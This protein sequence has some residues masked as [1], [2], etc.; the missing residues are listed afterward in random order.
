MNHRS[1]SIGVQS[2]YIPSKNF[3]IHLKQTLPL[4]F[5]DLFVLDV[6]E[7]ITSMDIPSLLSSFLNFLGREV[8]HHTGIDGVVQRLRQMCNEAASC[9]SE[10]HRSY[11]IE[12]VSKNPELLRKMASVLQNGDSF[13]C[14]ICI[15]PLVEP[16]ITCCAHMFCKKCILKAL[17]KKKSCCPLCRHHLSEAD[18]FSASSDKPCNEDE[19]NDILSSGVIANCSSKVSTLLNLLVSSRNENHLA[20]LVVF[21][22]FGNMLSLLEKPLKAAGFETD[23]E[24]KWMEEF[25]KEG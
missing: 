7:E 15:S 22:Q 24:T 5:T 17:L 23:L 9:P 10:P 11:T 19:N 8:A 18:L 1:S 13:D 3:K 25:G 4:E 16:T 2:P 12:D 6:G 21:S 20:K 14:R